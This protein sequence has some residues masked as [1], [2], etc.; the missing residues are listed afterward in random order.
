MNNFTFYISHI[1]N[2]HSST[3]I[4]KTLTYL[5][6][7]NKFTSIINIYYLITKTINNNYLTFTS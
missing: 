4:Y 5:Y 6:Y 2:K 7:K 1:N 3:F